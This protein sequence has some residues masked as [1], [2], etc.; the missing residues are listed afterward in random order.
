MTD[1]TGS[2][3][4]LITAIALVTDI[5]QSCSEKKPHR[6]FSLRARVQFL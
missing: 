5:E 4:P 3:L 2:E 1:V 6:V